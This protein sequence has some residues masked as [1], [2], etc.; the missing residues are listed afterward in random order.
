M[1]KIMVLAV[2]A[3]AA[4]AMISCGGQKKSDANKAECSQNC[5]V[6]PN[7][8]DQGAQVTNTNEQAPQC[9]TKCGTCPQAATCPQACPQ[10][11]DCPMA[12]ECP[13][14]QNCPRL[15]ECPKAQACPQ[16]CPQV[17]E[18]PKAQAAQSEVEVA[19]GATTTDVPAK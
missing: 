7:N 5:P 9:N 3:M 10:V 6:C 19:T 4:V 2:I 8:N 13:G 11:K 14:V 17:K 15:K 18:C 1:K 12:K 16:V